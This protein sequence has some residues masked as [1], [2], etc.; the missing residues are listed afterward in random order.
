MLNPPLANLSN[1][2]LALIVEHVADDTDSGAEKRLKRL[3]VVDRTFTLLCQSHLFKE[4]RLKGVKSNM[5]KTLKRA[6]DIL[7]RKDP[8]SF[9][10]VRKIRFEFSKQK[11]LS[12]LFQDRTFTSLMEILSRAPR[13]PYRI[14]IFDWNAPKTKGSELFVEGL[15]KSFFSRTLESLFIWDSHIPADTLLI[16]ATLKKLHICAVQI[17]LPK[18]G[19]ARLVEGEL[20]KLR[21]LDHRLS[22]GTVQW[23]L[24]G[25]GTRRIADLSQLRI[26]H[27]CPEDEE[28]M[29]LAQPI[30]DVAQ[31]TLEEL[32]LTH[33]YVNNFEEHRG[34]IPLAPLLEL[35]NLHQLR[36]F[37]LISGIYDGDPD[38]LD[39]IKDLTRVLSTIPAVNHLSSI[40][41]R[42][43]VYGKPPFE[44]VFKDTESQKWRALGEEIIRISSGKPLR[45]VLDIEIQN[46]EGDP[47]DYHD[48]IDECR[49]QRL[50]GHIEKEFQQ[51]RTMEGIKV[52]FFNELARRPED[53]SDG[54]TEAASDSDSQVY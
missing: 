14:K 5:I 16:S 44:Q 12:W 41:L 40:G 39:V 15:L 3:S 42:M 54:E 53:E 51:L 24:P 34:Y 9:S 19:T 35:R 4:L 2:L 36:V 31:E 1:E 25:G 46:E 23:M 38:R 13:P 47:L 29:A 20:P 43:W 7:K 18:D 8:A 30:L 22:F 32:H 17:V 37:K 27:M 21:K 11:D 33:S 52:D 10:F 6:Y 49:L 26:L 28:N 45:F 48:P 50:Y